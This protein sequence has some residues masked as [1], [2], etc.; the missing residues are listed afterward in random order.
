M[1]GSRELYAR[2]IELH[3]QRHI[4][5]C[6]WY[7]W[8]KANTYMIANIHMIH[9]W[10]SDATHMDG[11]R[12]IYTRIIDVHEQWH[13]YTCHWYACDVAH[14][15][16]IAHIHKIYKWKMNNVSYINESCHRYKYN[17]AHMQ[18]KESCYSYGGFAWVVCTNHRI[19]W[20]KAHIHMPLICM[21]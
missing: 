18:I 6:L 17:I 9:K 12:E 11:S 21:R 3:E 7:A 8:D 19:T 1:E 10:K 13:I 5:T 20:A 15:Y 16:M 14:T 2:I 4:Y